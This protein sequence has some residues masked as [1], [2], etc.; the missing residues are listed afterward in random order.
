MQVEQTHSSHS[1]SPKPC[2]ITDVKVKDLVKE[3][4]YVTTFVFK[5]KQTHTHTQNSTKHFCGSGWLHLP[6]F[7]RKRRIPLLRSGQKS[8]TASGFGARLVE[9]SLSVQLNMWAVFL[10][11]I[12]RDSKRTSRRRRF[13]RHIVSA[14]HGKSDA[15]SLNFT[16]VCDRERNGRSRVQSR[17][18]SRERSRVFFINREEKH[19]FYPR[20]Q[21]FLSDGRRAMC[22]MWLMVKASQ[23]FAGKHHQWMCARARVSVKK[24]GWMPEYS[25][26][27]SKTNDGGCM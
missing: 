21:Y 1:L 20:R 11:S 5:N 14:V 4:M 18:L 17:S 8:K 26:Y 12:Q 3:W 13:P 9:G 24:I 27:S 16:A 2:F 7:S 6:L 10:S 19:T 15:E 22:W 23:H 25:K